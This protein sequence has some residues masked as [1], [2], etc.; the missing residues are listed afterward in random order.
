MQK[1]YR[2]LYRVSTVALRTKKRENERGELK[3]E[4]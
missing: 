2:K 3:D 4:K 1:F